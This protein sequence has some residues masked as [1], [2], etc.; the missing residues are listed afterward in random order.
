MCC[1]AFINLFFVR[2]RQALVIISL[3]CCVLISET[4]ASVFHLFCP[5]ICVRRVILL[6]FR[7]E[8]SVF[9]NVPTRPPEPYVTCWGL[10]LADNGPDTHA[11]LGQTGGG[12]TMGEQSETVVM[13]AAE[14]V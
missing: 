10:H 4:A 3:W 1:H 14:S 12:A 13:V 9:R 11:S 5:L 6:L 2:L 8:C 7:H